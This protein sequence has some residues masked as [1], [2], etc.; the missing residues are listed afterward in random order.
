MEI[1]KNR[2]DLYKAICNASLLDNLGLFIGSGFTKSVIEASNGSAYNWAELL[3]KCCEEMD[4][5]KGILKNAGS[6]PQIATMICKQH[7]IN[8]EKSYTKSVTLLKETIAS[9]T[10]VTPNKIIRENYSTFFNAL[11][12]NWIAT[13]NYDMLLEDILCGKSL[14]ISP[15]SCFINVHNMVPIYHI[16]GVRNEPES[17]VITNEDYTY[18]FRPNDYRQARLPF[19]MKESLVVMIGYG[20]GDI[21]VAT[22]VDWSNNVFTNENKNYSFPIVQLLW[23]K[24][25]KDKPYEDESGIIIYEISDIFD[26][27]KDLHNYYNEYKTE[28]DNLIEKVNCYIKDFNESSPETIQK[29]IKNTYNYRMEIV[30]FIGSLSQEFGYVYI[31]YISFMRDVIKKLNQDAEPYGAFKAYDDK[32]IIILDIICT[33]PVEKMPISFLKFIAESFDSVA[34]YIGHSPGQSFSAY[35]TWNTRKGEIPNEFLHA[36]WDV[37]NSSED[38]SFF[39]LKKL[40]KTIKSNNQYEDLAP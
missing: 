19:L 13:T 29:Y 18:L 38:F 20:L 15:K 9:I 8:T 40:L 32:L 28:Y 1:I 36:I 31:S 10:D 23:K 5:D 35:N 7:S 3:E 11:N 22:A 27:F 37:I 34:Y 24:D 17:I 14:T 39:Y 21:N 25:P 26:F 6:Y 12:I 16:H 30:N 2:D 4:V 33:V